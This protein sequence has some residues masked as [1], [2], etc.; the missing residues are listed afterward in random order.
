[1]YRDMYVPKG[2]TK[3]EVRSA[4]KDLPDPHR[5]YLSSGNDEVA[6]AVPE[7]PGNNYVKPT[8]SFLE[9]RARHT[10]T[11]M[12]ILY[13]RLYRVFDWKTDRTVYAWTCSG[14]NQP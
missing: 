12:R 3:D 2:F 6:I 5:F 1:M 7:Y 9:D 10:Y 13:F 4:A 8:K 11:V 14:S